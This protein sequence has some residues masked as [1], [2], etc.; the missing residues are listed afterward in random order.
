MLLADLGADVVRVDRPGPP[1]EL[2]AQAGGT[3]FV[4][5][6][7]RVVE[8]DLRG[9][10]GQA[11][12]LDLADRADVLVEG[13]R[14]GVAERLGIGP[15]DCLERNPRLVYARMT[16]WGQDGP[17]S[18]RAGH[19]INYISI[20]GALH[21]IRTAGSRPT[22]PLNLVGDYGGGALYLVTGVLAALVERSDS[23]RG[24]VVDAA[25][26]DGVTSLLQGMWSLRGEGNWTD[27]PASNLLDTGVPYYDTYECKD[28]R[29]VA[30][31]ALEPKFFAELI[32]GLGLSPELVEVQTR[33]EWRDRLRERIGAAFLTRTRDEWA[34]HFGAGDACVTP[35][36]TF[37]EA[38]RHQHLEARHTHLRI[39]GV[40]QAGVAPR[41]SRS[42]PGAPRAP[43]DRE[44]GAVGVIAEWAGGRR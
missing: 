19:D 23:G 39:D 36:L 27:E 11:Q 31:G 24:Q 37:E 35:V 21:A 9:E 1:V 16:G 40:D 3:D 13:F 26:V 44:G 4:M 25:I 15:S 43:G 22:P 2:F 29:H 34:A 33:P 28:G 42:K 10:A 32:A 38:T 17:W 18:Q 20:T 30:V 5:R 6:G 7:K 14:P 41:F 8:L 12:A